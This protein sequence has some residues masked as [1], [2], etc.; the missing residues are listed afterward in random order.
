MMVLMYEPI[1]Y[2]ALVLI[3][4]CLGSFAGATVWRIRAHQLEYDKKHKE[5]YDKKEY[6]HLKKLLGKGTMADRSQCLSCGYTLR[7]YDLIPLI[8]WVGLKGRCR[9]CKHRIGAFEPLMEVGVAL[10]FVV[11]YALWPTDLA[12]GFEIAHFVLWLAAGVVMAILAAYDL[13]WFLLPDKLTG[14]LA[15]IGLGIVGVTA[16][17]S[18]DLGATVFNAILAVGAIAG[19]Y[20]AL[21][22]VS[23]GRWVGFGDVKLG[24]GLGLVLGQWELAVLTVFLANLIG[25]LIVIPLLM[26]KKIQ[27]NAHIPFGP[28]LILGATIAGLTG[29]MILDWYMTFLTI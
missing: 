23:G 18:S 22:F 7:W 8:S 10:F 14:L 24:V 26:T 3:G 12:N 20:A 1:I 16:V 4:L 2:L 28:L 27:R 5:P 13:K 29:W 25:C 15:G 11:S 17:T 9:S 19:L 6:S 21:F